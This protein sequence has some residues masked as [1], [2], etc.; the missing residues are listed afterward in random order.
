MTEVVRA[1]ALHRQLANIIREAIDSG[2]Y[3]VGGLLPSEDT[4]GKKHK[5]SRSTVRLALNTLRQQGLIAVRVGSGSTVLPG[6]DAKAVTAWRSAEAGPDRLIDTSEPDCFR[7]TVGERLAD[8]L[9]LDADEPTFVQVL[10][11]TDPDTGRRVISRRVLPFSACERTSL[12]TE[13]FPGRPELLAILAKAHK[14]LAAAEYIRP[15]IPAPDDATTLDLPEGTPILETTRITLA[16]G[17][18]VLAEIE[19]T[20]GDGIQHGYRLT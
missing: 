1:E 9:D 4:L 15:L 3:P 12:E 17:K 7:S 18:G 14:E 20:G 13:P 10:H 6:P 19:R 5:V 2:E 11:G 8:L 16:G